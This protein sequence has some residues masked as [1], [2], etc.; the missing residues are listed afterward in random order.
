MLLAGVDLVEGEAADRGG[1]L[2]VD[3]GVDH[4]DDPGDDRRGILIAA[5]GLA[6]DAVFGFDGIVVQQA[7]GVVPSGL[8]VDASSRSPT[9]RGA[10]ER[11]VTS[12]DGSLTRAVAR[13]R[14][15]ALPAAACSAARRAVSSSSAGSAAVTK[16][17]T[18]PTGSR[19]GSADAVIARRARSA[20]A[21]GGARRPRPGSRSRPPWSSSSAL[22]PRPARSGLPSCSSGCPA[23][24]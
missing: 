13:R 10:G 21:S 9:A 3:I 17:A 7:A 5:L 20:P 4:G 24:P 11:P 22:P 23:A 18:T 12:T 6:G 1:P 14:R 19:T 15:L 16:L 8:G 2:G